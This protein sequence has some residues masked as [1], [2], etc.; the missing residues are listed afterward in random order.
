MIKMINSAKS[1]MTK[2]IKEFIG[3]VKIQLQIN[4]KK[5]TMKKLTLI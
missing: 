4:S 5:L 2:Q 1:F 3:N